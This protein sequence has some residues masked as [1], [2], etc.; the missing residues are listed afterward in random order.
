VTKGRP[1]TEHQAKRQPQ[2]EANAAPPALEVGQSE[3]VAQRTA[4]ETELSA[5]L[6]KLAKLAPSTVD[7]EIAALTAKRP[8][9]N[10]E[11]AKK[12]KALEA[13]LTAAIGAARVVEYLHPYQGVVPSRTIL[14]LLTW[15]AA[16]LRQECATWSAAP[17]RGKGPPRKTENLM[18]ECLRKQGFTD[19][20]MARAGLAEDADQVRER[21][22]GKEKKQRQRARQKD[23]R[24]KRVRGKARRP[25]KK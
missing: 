1:K 8:E 19:E 7:L 16:L 9:A 22:R 2:G 13:A 11:I 5:W 25:L 15:A 21:R 6:D 12:T 18:L 4:R 3:T 24:H 14:G 10:R 23:R 17:P 20:Q